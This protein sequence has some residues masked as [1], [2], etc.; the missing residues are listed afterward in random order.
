MIFCTQAPLMSFI[1]GFAW[2]KRIPL[3]LGFFV[4]SFARLLEQPAVLS[5][6]F[7][8]YLTSNSSNHLSDIRVKTNM[9]GDSVGRWPVILLQFERED[10]TN[11]SDRA[12]SQHTQIIRQHWQLH[13]QTTG[14]SKLG[15]E[16]RENCFV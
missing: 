5:L 1:L 3:Y 9:R 12:S 10:P 6:L 13:R 7:I 16:R 14:W 2:Q 4:N 8:H 11:I 15:Q